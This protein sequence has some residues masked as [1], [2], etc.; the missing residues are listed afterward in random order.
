M[1]FKATID[2]FFFLTKNYVASG[3]VVTRGAGGAGRGKARE[4]VNFLPCSLEISAAGTWGKMPWFHS[5]FHFGVKSLLS[6]NVIIS[7][8]LRSF[9]CKCLQDLLE[10]TCKNT[11]KKK[12]IGIE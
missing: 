10:I 1:L 4:D 9:L 8:N 5:R 7:H 3:G 12:D 11:G 2:L 6:R